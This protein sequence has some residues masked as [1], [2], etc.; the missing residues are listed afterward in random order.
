MDND[1]SMLHRF[2]EEGYEALRRGLWEEAFHS[3]HQAFLLDGDDRG[4]LAS[5]KCVQY[6]KEM[7]EE[8]DHEWSAE[9][10]GDFYMERW[11]HFVSFLEHIGGAE[12]RCVFSCKTYV[13][14]SALRWYESASEGK[15]GESELMFKKGVC[16]KS[17]GDYEPARQTLERVVREFPRR[18]FFL[19][20]LADTYAL[21]GEVHLAKVFFREAFFHNPAE[22]ELAFLE[23][24][25]IN[26]LIS[27]VK[28]LG[29]EPPLL[30]E[31]LPVYGVLYGVFTVKRELKS[32][33]YGKL[34]QSIYA[35][36]GELADEHADRRTIIPRL[37]NRY[38]WLMDHYRINN[39]EPLKIQDTL[40]KI[41]LL[42]EKIYELYIH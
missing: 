8:V 4:I 33:E 40:Y 34:R 29:Y 7:E 21:M 38:F 3:F 9:E 2:V 30:Q 25:M 39:E 31:W 20:Q 22:I 35:L 11:K 19:S 32:L 26:R 37:L 23:S 18:S 28:E 16:E 12:E 6:W 24:E 1:I 27:R 15:E 5:L 36:E 41:R 17:L 10:K 14:S 42:D 13:F